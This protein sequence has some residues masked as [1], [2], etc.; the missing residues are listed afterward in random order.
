MSIMELVVS[1]GKGQI[2]IVEDFY[3]FNEDTWELIKAFAGIKKDFPVEVLKFLKGRLSVQRL[4]NFMIEAFKLRSARL[5]TMPCFDM[6]MYESLG[7][8]LMRMPR[9][10]REL[11][12]LL[13]LNCKWTFG[14]SI[15]LL[16]L[17]REI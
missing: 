8:E 15:F 14:D 7:G 17:I 2:T 10:D 16:L 1:S 9:R 13:S 12:E 4:N 6:H 3:L 11:Y 5:K